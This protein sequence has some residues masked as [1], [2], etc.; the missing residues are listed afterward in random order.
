M[1][2]SR[3]EI[4]F[5]PCCTSLRIKFRVGRCVT[6]LDGLVS[7]GF[8]KSGLVEERSKV[9]RLQWRILYEGLCCSVPNWKAF[10]CATNSGSVALLSNDLV[11]NY[12]IWAYLVP[13]C[14][15]ELEGR[16]I[17]SS[18]ERSCNRLAVSCRF[19]S[20][21]IA[22]LYPVLIVPHFGSDSLM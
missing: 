15:M 10:L 1:L 20:I 18:C 4:M 17:V 2:Q 12:D 19:T 14:L 22:P 9:R 11:C 5:T 13:L 3:G 16:P 21:F 7:W 6:L 8:R